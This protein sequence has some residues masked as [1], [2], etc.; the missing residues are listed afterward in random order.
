MLITGSAISTIVRW[1]SWILL[2]Q[3]FMQGCQSSLGI[4][5]FR[6]RL[7]ARVQNH[8]HLL[9]VREPQGLQQLLPFLVEFALARP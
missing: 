9:K 7:R 8:L 1:L 3:T 4:R 5:H 6:F 2:Y